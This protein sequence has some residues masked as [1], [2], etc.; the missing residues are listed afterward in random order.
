MTVQEYIVRQYVHSPDLMTA[1]VT[2]FGEGV[3]STEL[4]R[5]PLI[6][7]P[8]PTDALFYQSTPCPANRRDILPTDAISC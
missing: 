8:L 3:A 5:P 2:L 4:V 7:Y 6:P 1:Y